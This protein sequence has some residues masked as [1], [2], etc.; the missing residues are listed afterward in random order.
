[1]CLSF[2]STAYELLS[3]EEKRKNYD[4]YGDEKGNPGFHGGHPGGQDGYTYFTGGGPG[5]SHFN[6][7]PGGDWQ[8]AYNEL[9]DSIS[10]TYRL[11][12][13]ERPRT[14]KNFHRIAYGNVSEVLRKHF[15]SIFLRGN[16]F[17]TQ[18]SRNA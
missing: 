4:L 12:T 7:K 3:D 10:G 6:F 16:V 2:L 11:K 17:F 9:K 5:Q 15:D 1:M 13:E 18:N 14:M 8:G